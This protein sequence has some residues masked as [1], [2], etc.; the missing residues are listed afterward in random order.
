[1]LKRALVAATAIAIGGT[2]AA[3][4]PGEATPVPAGARIA[5]ASA[6]SSASSVRWHRCDDASLRSNNLKCGSIKVPLD[7]SHPHGRKIT[8]APQPRKSASS[9]VMSP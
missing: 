5:A 4:V 7:Y 3:T 8:L 2:L 6:Q 1:M 9:T